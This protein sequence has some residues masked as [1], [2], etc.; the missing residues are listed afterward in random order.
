V[1]GIVFIAKYILLN[2]ESSGSLY[3]RA[4]NASRFGLFLNAPLVKRETVSGLPLERD[5][6]DPEP[7]RRSFMKVDN[8]NP[9]RGRAGGQRPSSS[10]LFKLG[11][12]ALRIALAYPEDRRFGLAMSHE[13][14]LSHQL[15]TF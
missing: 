10:W 4:E 15:T 9:T 13:V 14:R 7:T 12:K 8:T 3:L 6:I 5:T 2:M 1:G 11:L